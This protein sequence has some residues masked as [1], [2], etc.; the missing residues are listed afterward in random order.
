KSAIEYE[1]ADAVTAKGKRAEL[2]VWRALWASVEPGE[3]AAKGVPIVGREH[4]LTFLHELWRRVV[5]ERRPHLLTIFG[6]AGVGKTRLA[7]TG[8][9]APPYHPRAAGSARHTARLGRRL[10][11]LHGASA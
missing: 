11:R 7:H 10:A 6:P 1:Q 2:R 5:A 3:R 8:R 4:E 9:A